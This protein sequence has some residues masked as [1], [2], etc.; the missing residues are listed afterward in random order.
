MSEEGGRERIASEVRRML[1]TVR[2]GDYGDRAITHPD[3]AG[4]AQAVEGKDG[5][6]LIW[7]DTDGYESTE[8]G[9]IIVSSVVKKMDEA[10][11]NAVQQGASGSF[12]NT[13]Y[14]GTVENEGVG[15]APFHDFEGEVSDE[16][17]SELDDLRGQI[18]SG[19]LTVES[20]NTPK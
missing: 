16:L 5:A 17:K 7:V 8:Y 4:A 9:D 11:F 1:D 10:V 13:P 18:A 6:K 19:D 3:G 12:D 20:E 14:V 15:L 2:L